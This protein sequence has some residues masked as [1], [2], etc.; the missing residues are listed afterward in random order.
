MSG[1]RRDATLDVGREALFAGGFIGVLWFAAY[2]YELG[3]LARFGV[4][5]T[6]ADVGFPKALTLAFLLGSA[7]GFLGSLCLMLAGLI[8]GDLRTPFLAAAVGAALLLVA[9][10]LGLDGWALPLALSAEPRL[11][12]F[13]L[14]VLLVL[15]VIVVA[16]RIASLW[17]SLIGE[18]QPIQVCQASFLALALMF[19]PITFGWFGAVRKA[20]SKNTFLY[21][22]DDA[23][24]VLVRLYDDLAI[25][26]RYDA[27]TQ[28]FEEE[29][30]VVPL[31]QGKE[32]FVSFRSARPA[33]QVER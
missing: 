10:G 32:A 12:P 24:Y 31:G 18:G 20:E 6:L 1:N 5:P 9:Y 30:R 7:G 14:R 25:F 11:M 27:A 2:L 21:L 26:V 4:P 15:C 23:N 17:L 33:S 16:A 29:Y 19:V 8:E 3:F 22:V 28:V 13:W